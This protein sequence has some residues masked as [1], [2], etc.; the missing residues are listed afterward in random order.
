MLAGEAQDLNIGTVVDAASI[1]RDLVE[2]C[3]TGGQGRI[4]DGTCTCTDSKGNEATMTMKDVNNIPDD[5]PDGNDEFHVVSYT[6]DELI[7]ARTDAI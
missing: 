7:R 3:K 6:T 4:V 5:K 1:L 2:C